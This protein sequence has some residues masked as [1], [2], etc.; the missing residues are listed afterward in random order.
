MVPDLHLLSRGAI[1]RDVTH[2]TAALLW[3]CLPVGLVCFWMFHAWFREPL[4]KLLPERVAARVPPA[5][6]W[7]WSDLLPVSVS[8]LVGAGTHILWDALTHDDSP[9]VPAWPWLLHSLGRI[10]DYPL[11]VYR[12]LQH[13][14]TTL[15]LIVLAVWLWVK[16]R[17]APA[18]ARVAVM[19]ARMR[20][21][22]L[23]VTVLSAL[24]GVTLALALY[25]TTITGVRSVLRIAKVTSLYAIAGAL[26]ALLVYC[27]VWQIGLGQRAGSARRDG[28]R[29]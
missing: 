13:G 28:D 29:R 14:S 27:L 9:L 12:V 1:P 15:G 21:F 11:Y 18:Q 16:W 24:L 8:L 2:S 10:G 19:S 6:R 20:Q 25:P 5:R 4:L 26:A 23:G 7:Q 3:F 17:Q 22:W